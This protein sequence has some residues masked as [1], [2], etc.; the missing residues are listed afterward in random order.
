MKRSYSTFLVF[1]LCVATVLSYPGA[2]SSPPLKTKGSTRS[3]HATPDGQIHYV[4]AGDFS[5]QTTL[6]LLHGHPRSTTEFR[7][8]VNDLQG[9]YAFVA[10]DFFGFGASDDCSSCDPDSGR[11]VDVKQWASYVIEVMDALEVKRFVPLGSLKGTYSA[12]YITQAYP[13]R[14]DATVLVLPLWLN[15]ATLTKIQGY[16][17]AL[18]HPH[19]Y[20]TGSHL[21]TAW[22]DTSAG[23]G[24][25]IQHNEDKTLDNLRSLTGS[26]AYL[27]HMF[28]MNNDLIEALG[29][30]SHKTMIVW[31]EKA[32]AAWDMYNFDTATSCAKI[33]KAVQASGSPLTVHK[34]PNGWESSVAQN[35]SRIA[36]WI[37]QFL[38]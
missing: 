13:D 20:S 25:D 24:M 34:L 15:N 6:L 17:E 33:E 12:V 21:I 35:S 11:H 3:F 4:T 27:W 23:G 7:G 37:E 36:S 16:M 9:K 31:G 1:T 38:G 32:L 2:T 10:L 14:I 8:L 30:F 19:L 26:W 5:T 29:S 22:N 18:K 28:D